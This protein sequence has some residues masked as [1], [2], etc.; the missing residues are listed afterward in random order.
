MKLNPG[1]KVDFVIREDGEVFI[2]ISKS[3]MVS[4]TNNAKFSMFNC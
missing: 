4:D 2:R 3:A 1:D